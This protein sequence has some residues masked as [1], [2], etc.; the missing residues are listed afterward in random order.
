MGHASTAMVFKVYGK[1]TPKSLAQKVAS[2]SVPI[3]P[4]VYQTEGKAVDTA[5]PLDASNPTFTAVFG[6]P[7]GTRTLDL[8]IKSPQL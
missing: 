1:E 4:L 7:T 5:D 8:R 2:A 6:G 3:V